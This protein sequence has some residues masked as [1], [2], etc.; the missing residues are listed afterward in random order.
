VGIIKVELYNI[1][2]Y[3]LKT[4]NQEHLEIKEI[5]IKYSHL[6]WQVVKDHL[7]LVVQVL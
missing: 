2:L 7:D 4:E 5:I 1:L 6:D 3:I